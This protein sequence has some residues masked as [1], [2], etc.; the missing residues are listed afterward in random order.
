MP[1]SNSMRPAPKLNR[2]MTP[3][4][5]PAPNVRMRCLR[6]YLPLSPQESGLKR[7]ERNS[8]PPGWKLNP[9]LFPVKLR[10][11]SS[12]SNWNEWL[13]KAIQTDHALSY[14]KQ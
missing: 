5:E 12:R 3:A 8:H 11:L 6:N 1:C 13:I 10:D 9:S 2:H 4:H 14:D 7:K